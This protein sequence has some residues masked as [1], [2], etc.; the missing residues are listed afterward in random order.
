MRKQVRVDASVTEPR[1]ALFPALLT[2][3]NALDKN[4]KVIAL[5]FCLTLLTGTGSWLSQGLSECY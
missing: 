3:L 5:G 1:Q 2:G 4:L